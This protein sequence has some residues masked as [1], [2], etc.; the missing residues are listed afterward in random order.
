MN[1]SV[2][3][4]KGQMVSFPLDC[5]DIYVTLVLGTSLFEPCGLE[6]NHEFSLILVFWNLLMNFSVW[7]I[8]AHP[9]F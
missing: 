8:E 2:I 5:D 4:S 6:K 7:L 3:A 1:K 9:I